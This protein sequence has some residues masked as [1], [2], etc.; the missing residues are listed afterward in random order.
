[1]S[2]YLR[3]MTSFKQRGG[4]DSIPLHGMEVSRKGNYLMREGCSEWRSRVNW[5]REAE[6]GRAGQTLPQTEVW[7]PRKLGRGLTSRTTPREGPHVA[8]DPGGTDSLE[9]FRYLWKEKEGECLIRP[10]D[11]PGNGV[12][13]GLCGTRAM[14]ESAVFLGVWAR[15]SPRQNTCL[16]QRTA[17]ASKPAHQLGSF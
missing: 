2:L 14:A 6:E 12:C 16:A 9:N 5:L 1:M 15:R 8:H 13:A 7:G 10:W 17:D 3:K 4:R 11:L